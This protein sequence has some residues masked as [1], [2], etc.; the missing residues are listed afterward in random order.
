MTLKQI[1]NEKDTFKLD[2]G[3]VL[4]EHIGTRDMG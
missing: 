3:A 4:S 1:T 2:S